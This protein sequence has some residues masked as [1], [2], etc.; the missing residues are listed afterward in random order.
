MDSTTPIQ[1]PSSSITDEPFPPVDN[2][3]NLVEKQEITH[4]ILGI[5]QY[6]SIHVGGRLFDYDAKYP[7]D[8]P[9]QEASDNARVWM[10]CN[11]EAEIYDADMLR[12]FRDTIDSLLVFA[13]LFSAVVT[14]FVVETARVFEPDHAKITTYLLVEQN[15]LLRA[16]GNTTSINS[17]PPSPYAPGTRSYSR[18]DIAVNILFFMSLALALSSALFSILVK[19]WITAYSSQIPGTPKEVALIRNLR[20]VGLQKWKLPEFIGV[21]PLFMHVALGIFA[22]G[23]LAF[24]SQ[25]NITVFIAALAVFSVTGTIYLISLLLPPFFLDCPY[26][27]FLLDAPLRFLVPNIW[28]RILYYGRYMR[29]AAQLL[30]R[31][32]CELWPLHLWVDK[33]KVRHPYLSTPPFLLRRT[34]EHREANEPSNVCDTV[35]WLHDYS[36]NPTIRRTAAKALAGVLPSAPMDW[37]VMRWIYDKKAPSRLAQAYDLTQTLWSQLAISE[38]ELP[39][40]SDQFHSAVEPTSSNYNPWV[41]A[42]FLRYSWVYHW[43]QNGQLDNGGNSY[44]HVANRGISAFNHNARDVLVPFF[45][46]CEEVLNP[47]SGAWEAPKTEWN[48]MNDFLNRTPLQ[49]IAACGYVNLVSLVSQRADVNYVGDYAKPIDIAID[50]AEPDLVQAF[51]DAGADLFPSLLTACERGIVGRVEFI[52]GLPGVVERTGDEKTVEESPFYAAFHQDNSEVVRI[53]VERG[54]RVSELICHDLLELG[55]TS[56]SGGADMVAILSQAWEVECADKKAHKNDET[57]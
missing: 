1:Q 53:L 42:E 9:G 14:T 35:A 34:W 19:Q 4:K 48:E 50:R 30:T 31:R 57:P 25:Q 17:I 18:T 13:A 27:I 40:S 28:Q 47:A 55:Q 51:V 3:Q 7:E 41:R 20:F 37:E 16:N 54:V 6:H 39:H 29:W 36:S 44:F 5:P 11:E 38:S 56:A 32:I 45:M 2:H 10:I 12:G 46:T 15:L 33:I 23:L 21:L 43:L 49:Y 24:I 22:A 26:H 8:P 52:L